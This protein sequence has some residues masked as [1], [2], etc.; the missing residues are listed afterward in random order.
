MELIAA[1]DRELAE[2]ALEAW[3]EQLLL[4][5]KVRFEPVAGKFYHQA[6]SS[7][8]AEENLRSVAAE[9]YGGSN[10]AWWTDNGRPLHASETRSQKRS[11]GSPGGKWID[12]RTNLAGYR[13]GRNRIE[14]P[15]QYMLAVMM[16]L[17]LCSPQAHEAIEM[18]LAGYSKTRIAKEWRAHRETV[19]TAI[20][21]AIGFV[22][23]HRQQQP[24]WGP[25]QP[26]PMRTR[27]C[28]WGD[29][30]PGD[31]ANGWPIER[32]IAIKPLPRR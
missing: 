19:R 5:G 21:F 28:F 2:L 8:P 14:A 10:P 15:T 12:F 9:S 23:Y 25:K 17:N 4:N 16:R 26:S 22:H 11:D 6:A 7:V 20:D 13:G 29:L 27:P 24:H 3:Y 32:S 30:A 31:D 18:T 1:R